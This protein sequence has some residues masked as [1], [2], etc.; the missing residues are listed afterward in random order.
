MNGTEFDKWLDYHCNVQPSVAN[1]VR[2]LPDQDTLLDSWAAGMADVPFADAKAATDM[3]VKG[4]VERPFPEDTCRT[5]RRTALAMA[6]SRKNTQPQPEYDDRTCQLCRGTGM[7]TIW[8][9]LT[10]RS[11]RTGCQT[12]QTASGAIRKVADNSGAVPATKAA[13]ACRCGLGERFAKWMVKDGDRWKAEPRPRFGDSVN[14][15]PVQLRPWDQIKGLTNR[16]RIELD[17]ED[18]PTLATEW[19]WDNAVDP[20]PTERLPRFEFRKPQDEPRVQTQFGEF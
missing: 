20:Q 3:I 12:F 6:V 16:Q 10:V 7:V 2:G 5:V 15:V 4:D 1:W 8:H 9:P 11:I 17:M 18:R 13:V 19:S 14:H